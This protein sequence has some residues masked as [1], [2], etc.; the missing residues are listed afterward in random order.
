MGRDMQAMFF[1]IF[2]APESSAMCSQ[3]Q[4]K[5][6]ANGFEREVA[7]ATERE[8]GSGMVNFEW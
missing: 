1:A 5:G 8:G 3:M 7:E 2:S 6:G 4:S